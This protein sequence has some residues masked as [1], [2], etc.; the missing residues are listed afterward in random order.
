MNRKLVLCAL[1]LLTTCYIDGQNMSKKKYAQW[2]SYFENQRIEKK[3]S[4][5]KNRLTNFLFNPQGAPED[6]IYP[7]A[8]QVVNENTDLFVVRKIVEGALKD[9][10]QF[11]Q[12][13]LFLVFNNRK[14]QDTGM[15]TFAKL[16]NELLTSQEYELKD[17]YV[18][19]NSYTLDKSRPYC[20]SVLVELVT[21]ADYE[22][23]KWGNLQHIPCRRD[24]WY[25]S[26]PYFN[27]DYLGKIIDRL[28]P[29][30]GKNNPYP[31]KFINNGKELPLTQQGDFYTLGFYLEKNEE[32]K[33]TPYFI[34][35]D[36]DGNLIDTCLMYDLTT[37]V[38]YDLDLEACRNV[39]LIIK[40][41]GDKMLLAVL[42]NDGRFLRQ[43]QAKSIVF[44]LEKRLE[45]KEAKM[46]EK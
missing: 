5:P 19:I 7:I 37:E 8:H 24:E 34:S 26:S 29:Y 16:E 30:P 25:I 11:N 22:L 42:T 10:E 45:E 23:D 13:D 20:S 2:L 35:Q 31:L 36:M 38:I 14:L 40:Y 3:E 18:H 9:Y 17:G 6:T 43:A 44:E 27:D 1:L 28:D 12:N 33:L 39:P 32:G 4:L 46:K 15:L 21:C 41:N